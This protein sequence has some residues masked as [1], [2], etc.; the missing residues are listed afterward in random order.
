[1]QNSEKD[2][3]QIL[4]MHFPEIQNTQLSLLLYFLTIGFYVSSIYR[5]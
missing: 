3:I 4:L 5:M 2:S 1:M